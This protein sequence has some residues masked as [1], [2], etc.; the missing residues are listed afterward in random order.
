MN[1]RTISGFQALW[2]ATALI[3][4]LVGGKAQAG[5]ISPSRSDR[6]ERELNV[7]SDSLRR[8]A[9]AQAS[10][11]E[12]VP[13]DEAARRANDRALAPFFDAL[14]RNVRSL[15]VSPAACGEETMSF[16]ARHGFLGLSST[17]IGVNISSSAPVYA[18]REL[19]LGQDLVV[20]FRTMTVHISR[21]SGA[22]GRPV[23][24]EMS[25]EAWVRLAASRG[26][27]SSLKRISERAFVAMSAISQALPI[28][29]IGCPR[30]L[31]TMMLR[32]EDALENQRGT[33]HARETEDP[34][35]SI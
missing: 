31:E 5:D 16:R 7:T 9:Q 1:R 33:G 30:F 13:V 14:S 32:A 27:D 21:G 20:D 15:R 22:F 3:A 23:R 19:S 11:S 29:A 12:Q 8:F 4:S 18:F 34:G 17:E 28:L 25:F 24:T 26:A 2:T 6:T 10:P 35:V